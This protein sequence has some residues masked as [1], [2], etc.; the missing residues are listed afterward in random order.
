MWL[1]EDSVG[2]SSAEVAR[3]ES[4]RARRAAATVDPSLYYSSGY[5]TED[6]LQFILVE[7]VVVDG[8]VRIAVALD[9]PGSSLCI[10]IIIIIIIITDLYSAFRSE[11]TEA[12]DGAWRLA[13]RR[14]LPGLPW[15]WIYMDLSMDIY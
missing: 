3:R 5:Y 7:P 2:Q 10:I 4:N 1:L 15:I 9:K 12:L 11:D 13:Q 6:D 14:L 8:V